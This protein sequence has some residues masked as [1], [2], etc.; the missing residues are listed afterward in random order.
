MTMPPRVAP[1][2]E[3]EDIDHDDRPDRGGCAFGFLVVCGGILA[4]LFFRPCRRARPPAAASAGITSSKSG[5]ALHNYADT[6]GTFPPAYIAD[7]L[8]TTYY[9]L[10]SADS[11]FP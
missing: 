3:E 2:P 1:R 9:Q 10:A 7:G 5:L 6:Y 8:E 11:T 4:A